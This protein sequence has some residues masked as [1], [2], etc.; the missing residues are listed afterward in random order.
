[1]LRFLSIGESL[2]M[3]MSLLLMMLT[4]SRVLVENHLPLS[5]KVRILCILCT[6]ILSAVVLSLSFFLVV[7][8]VFNTKQ[9][10]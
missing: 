7:V 1:M 10:R 2:L 6:L 8:I 4:C 3:D 5:H 9:S